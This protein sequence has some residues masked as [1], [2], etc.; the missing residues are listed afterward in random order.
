M[1]LL[2]TI[3]VAV[4]LRP[5]QA[6][7]EVIRDFDLGATQG[8]G[9][10]NYPTSWTN[11]IL[12][13]SVFTNSNVNKWKHSASP[14][15]V[16]VQ[17]TDSVNNPPQSHDFGRANGPFK[18]RYDSWG[19][20]RNAAKKN[21]KLHWDVIM[22]TMYNSHIEKEQKTLE[23]LSRDVQS[24]LNSMYLGKVAAK[25]CQPRRPA[26][27]YGTQE[28]GS[29]SPNAQ[30]CSWKTTDITAHCAAATTP[31]GCA[32][33]GKGD[34]K[35]KQ[36]GGANSA[37]TEECGAK[38]V[39]DTNGGAGGLNP[40]CKWNGLGHEDSPIQISMRDTKE[41][42]EE[43]VKCLQNSIKNTNYESYLALAQHTTVGSG[44]IKVEAIDG[45][46][47]STDA[48]KVDAVKGFSKD[49]NIVKKTE[50]A[51]YN[52]ESSY[53]CSNEEMHFEVRLYKMSKLE[54]RYK[55]LYLYCK[56]DLTTQIR[57]FAKMVETL[58]GATNN[59]ATGHRFE[60]GHCYKS[61]S[62]GHNSKY[63]ATASDRADK[64][65]S[66]GAAASH[67]F[68][69]FMKKIRISQ[70]DLAAEFCPEHVFYYRDDGVGGH[71]AG[72]C[73]TCADFG[74][75]HSR[76]TGTGTQTHRYRGIGPVTVPMIKDG[77]GGA[78]WSR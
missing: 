63:Y 24:Q 51:H 78:D 31:D 74:G 40:F 50:Q 58:C 47:Y 1:R 57:K 8:T 52:L 28:C 68:D 26:V 60:T 56:C 10:A 45:T 29:K 5:A 72:D 38:C 65:G 20:W 23:R 67:K 64:T 41:A 7:G 73:S 62:R 61:G 12:P 6:G 39:D 54:N 59:P 46:D 17:T 66:T 44:N 21:K 9:T 35:A 71:P 76:I 75:D 53:K 43:L 4:C 2:F 36:D 42:Y 19:N 15:D 34:A 49:S 33:K 14:T 22:G 3:G 77:E 11:R 32:A 16:P 25:G 70:C 27:S 55:L 37:I 48:A 30:R 18:P 13:P 69:D